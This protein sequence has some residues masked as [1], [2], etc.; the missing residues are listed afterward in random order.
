MYV[1]PILRLAVYN[2]EIFYPG[3]YLIVESDIEYDISDKT[4]IR[5]K[6]YDYV[7]FNTKAVSNA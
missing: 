6:T 3:I 7:I 5:N 4:A 2:K 1:T